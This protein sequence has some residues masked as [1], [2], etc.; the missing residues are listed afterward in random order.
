MRSIKLNKNHKQNLKQIKK[1]IAEKYYKKG[2]QDALN[3]RKRKQK[4][5][6]VGYNDG[7][8]DGY[9]DAKT[10]YFLIENNNDYYTKEDFLHNIDELL[11]LDPQVQH[12]CL[13][14]YLY[15]EITLKTFN[16]YLNNKDAF[17]ELY[18]QILT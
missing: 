10:Y 1:E 5:Y 15:D 14:Q 3:S 18:L 11:A 9:N 17:V 6:Q 13:Y 12:E 2:Y 16:Y 8:D 4:T 7:Y